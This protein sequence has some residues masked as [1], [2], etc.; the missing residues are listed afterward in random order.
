MDGMKAQLTKVRVGFISTACP[1]FK[2]QNP[3]EEGLA[4]NSSVL[5][6]TIPWTEEAGGLQPLAQLLTFH[7]TTQHIIISSL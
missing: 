1:S 5:P 7:Y 6:W 2:R 4:T 3:L